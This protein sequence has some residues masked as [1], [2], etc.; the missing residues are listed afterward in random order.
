M[1][2]ILDTWAFEKLVKQA[3]SCIGAENLTAGES[4]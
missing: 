1:R 2:K 4:L 3:P